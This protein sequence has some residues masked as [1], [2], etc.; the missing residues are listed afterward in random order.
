MEIPQTPTKEEVTATIQSEVMLAIERLRAYEDL[1]DLTVKCGSQTFEVH[2]AVL[3]PRSA[4]FEAA[5]RKNGFREGQQSVITI[6]TMTSSDSPETDNVGKD[7]EEAIKHM[8][9]YFYQSS[10]TVRRITGNPNNERPGYRPPVG[11]LAKIR[12]SLKPADEDRGL[13][14]HAHVYA[15]AVKY[16]VEGLELLAYYNFKTIL[17]RIS[18][19]SYPD[20]AEAINVAYTTTPSD[21][22]KL[23]DLIAHTLANPG[24]DAIDDQRIATAVNAIEGLGLEVAKRC[25]LFV[26][27]RNLDKCHHTHAYRCER[28]HSIVVQCVACAVQDNV[29]LEKPCQ[30]GGGKLRVC[31]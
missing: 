17:D 4:W 9:G 1:F 14:M 22:T 11:G 20:L 23:R 19:V 12:A 28:C 18:Q 5:C 7:H 26:A 13:T 24:I 21:K 16:G 8:I 30:K 2:K 31:K 29:D 3:C 10:Y 15:T 27:G 25:R 6:E